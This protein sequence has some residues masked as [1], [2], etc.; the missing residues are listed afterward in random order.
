MTSPTAPPD[1][2]DDDMSRASGWD[3][4]LDDLFGLNVRAL[5]TMRAILVSPRPVFE[6]AREMDW[7]GRYTPSIRLVFTLIAA[8]VFLRF[9]WGGEG[10]ALHEMTREGFESERAILGS[11]VDQF[12]S[13]YLSIWLVLFPFAYFLVHAPIAF[14]LQIWGKGTPATVRFRLY[15]AALLPGLLLGLLTTVAIPFMNVAAFEAVLVP[16]LALTALIYAAT[17]FRGLPVE[18]MAGRRMWRGALFG[19]IA[20][21]AD[22]LIAISTFVVG[23]AWLYERGPV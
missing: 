6:A 3:A 17:V 2:A 10:S 9:L 13:D 18:I 4:L 12:T 5:N 16:A 14:M 11:G 23:Y 20:V 19:G 7:S 8:M 22:L 1:P 15:F 21:C